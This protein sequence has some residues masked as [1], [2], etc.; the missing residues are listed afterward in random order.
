MPPT[1]VAVV[2]RSRN[3]IVISHHWD[4]T[5]SSLFLKYLYTVFLRFF[6]IMTC[7]NELSLKYFTMTINAHYNTKYPIHSADPALVSSRLSYAADVNLR[8]G[9]PNGEG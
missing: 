6:F 9:K 7:L 2:P 1:A 4:P 8:G 3:S 5:L